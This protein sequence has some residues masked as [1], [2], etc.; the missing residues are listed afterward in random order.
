MNT[1]IWEGDGTCDNLKNCRYVGLLLL[2][3]LL[4]L[5]GS[6]LL[7]AMLFFHFYREYQS[8]LSAR[9][10]QRLDRPAGSNYLRNGYQAVPST[11]SPLPMSKWANLKPQREAH[12]L[13]QV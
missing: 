3:P 5:Y 8:Q 12:W 11:V 4:V 10:L 13:I 1:K 9:V 2:A 6:Y 7:A